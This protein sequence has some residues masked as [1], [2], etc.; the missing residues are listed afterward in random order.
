ETREEGQI[1][2][3]IVNSENV[4]HLLSVGVPNPV[5]NVIGDDGEAQQLSSDFKILGVA[6]VSYVPVR[7]EFKALPH[8]NAT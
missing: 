3:F 7:G 4:H 6:L 1:L 8:V 5:D 2:T